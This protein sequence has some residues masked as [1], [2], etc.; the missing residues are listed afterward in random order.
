[1]ADAVWSRIRHEA[2]P[3][4]RSKCGSRS[5]PSVLLKSGAAALRGRRLL[6]HEAAVAVSE[7]TVA[8]EEAHTDRPPIARLV[9]ISGCRQRHPKRDAVVFDDDC[10][11]SLIVAVVGHFDRPSS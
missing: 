7:A 5:L 1:M 10:Q 2:T 11:G 6:L 9:L 4:R 8:P 3:G